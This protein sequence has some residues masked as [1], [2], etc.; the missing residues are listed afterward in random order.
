[1]EVPKYEGSDRRKRPRRMAV[2]PV[3]VRS[4]EPQA[5][6]IA[7]CT[8]DIS[9]DG[10]RLNIS[11]WAPAPGDIINVERGTEK[12]MFR[13]AWVGDPAMG[14][15]GQVG[16]QCVEQGKSIFQDKQEAKSGAAKDDL[17][18]LLSKK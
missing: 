16:I 5:K 6:P 10:A 7:A 1:M 13:I 12:S 15:R 4:T 17:M 3:K 9:T 11:G 8:L 14:R 2:V 18:R